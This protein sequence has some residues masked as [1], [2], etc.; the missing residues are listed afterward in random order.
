MADIHYFTDGSVIQIQN[1][2][3]GYGSYGV[4][5]LNE[6]C[7]IL[8]GYVGLA[9]PD[10][11]YLECL[12][13]HQALLNVQS[14]KINNRYTIYTDSDACYYRLRDLISGINT[15]IVY[16][17]NLLNNQIKTTSKFALSLSD[18]GY[19][20]HIFCVRS[21][22]NNLN[23]QKK[24]LRKNGIDISN[25][26]AA[27]I[28]KGNKLVDYLVHSTALFQKVFKSVPINLVGTK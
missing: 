7:R 5:E 23:E 9:E 4:L 18:Q 12:A 25:R 21:H 28:N 27:F 11:N 14:N 2:I 6:R 20:I 3:E 1:Q 16:D 26:D 10:I 22:C 17:D 24:F 15:G 13:I 8:N 19:D